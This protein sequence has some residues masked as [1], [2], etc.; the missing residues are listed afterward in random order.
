MFSAPMI[1]HV[2]NFFRPDLWGLPAPSLKASQ[3]IICLL[4][5][6]VLSVAFWLVARSLE[7]LAGLARRAFRAR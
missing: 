1:E 6:L 7:G 4:A 2:A 3:G 5:T